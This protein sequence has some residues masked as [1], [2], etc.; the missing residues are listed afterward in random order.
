VDK[1]DKPGQAKVV[2]LMPQLPAGTSVT[3]QEGQMPQFEVTFKKQGQIVIRTI[4][5][6]L[7]ES[8]EIQAYHMADA[9]GSEIVG[10][11]RPVAEG[12]GGDQAD[13]LINDV[14]VPGQEMHGADLA[15]AD[16]EEG[17]EFTGARQKAIK[18]GQEHFTVDGKTY[19]VTGDSSDEKSMTEGLGRILYLSGVRK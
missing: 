14:A 3:V 7:K 12:L 2:K 19:P 4:S 6:V 9:T 17:N 8:A 18:A 15:E 13:D 10:D 11:V 5:A 1:N 16:M